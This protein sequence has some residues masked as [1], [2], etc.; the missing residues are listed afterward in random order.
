MRKGLNKLMASV[1]AGAMAMSVASTSF[2]A[3]A[4]DVEGT[5]YVEPTRVLSAL[6]IMVGDK[7]TGLFRPEDQIKRSEVAKIA[8][9]AMGLES[10]ALMSNGPTKYPD[11]VENHWANGYINV[12]TSQGLIIGDPDGNFRPDDSISY[13][14]AM[15]IMVRMIGHEPSALEKGGYPNG[16]LVVGA[17][18]DINKN[19]LGSA[20]DK[21]NRGTVAF[22]TYNS[23][24]VK[25][26]ERVGAGINAGYEEVDKTLLQ[27]KLKT[28][29][30][31]GQ[32]TGIE[33]TRLSGNSSLKDGEI[34][35]DGEVYKM[36]ENF[37]NLL[38]YN[39]RYYIQENDLG[40]KEVILAYAE[41]GK[42][43][44]EDI[45]AEQFYAIEDKGDSKIIKYKKNVNDNKVSSVE[46]EKEPTLIYNGKAENLDYDLI[47]LENK[48]GKINLL[49]TD[50]NG[51][52]DIIFVTEYKNIVVSD[53]LTSS[54]KIVDMYGNNALTLDPEDENIKF[55]IKKGSQNIELKD[56][57]KWDVLSIAA[58]KD[59][60]VYEI[61]V[62]NNKVEGKVDGISADEVSIGGVD[63]KIADNYKEAINLNTEGVFYLDI[64]GK[65]AAVD[66]TSAISNN[67]AY[68][69]NAACT[70]SMLDKCEIKVFTKEG[71]TEYKE[72]ASSIKLN[73]EARKTKED[74]LNAL[75]TGQDGAV[76]PQLITYELN[77]EGKVSRI[78][79][80]ND[81]SQTGAI[82]EETFTLNQKLEQATFNG[83]TG[84]LGN[85]NVNANTVIFNIPADKED[86]EDFAIADMSIFEHDAKYDAL[87]FDMGK[88]FTAKAIIVTSASLKTDADAK[89]AIVK[90]V[91][92]SLNAD[93]DIV[94]KLTAYC[95]GQEI[96]LLTE[97]EG[98]LVKGEDK[99]LEAGDI[100]QYKTNSKNEISDM[101]ILFD[102]N[103][104]DAEATNAPAE[105]LVT[106]YGKVVDKFDGSINVSVDGVVTNLNVKNAKVY[107]VDTTLSN[108][109][110][111]NAE[112]ADIEKYEGSDSSKVFV[113]IYKD[114]VQEIVIVK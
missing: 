54:H 82:D 112:T 7:D 86:E 98:F 17:E 46:L 42:N 64:E 41:A 24:E 109:V 39:V 4:S 33:N 102:I 58:S 74:V 89:I 16:Y 76:E 87:V 105:N 35:I 53:V 34:E 80:A 92:Q 37:N 104:K 85:V 62:I 67:Y 25:L 94:D 8:V 52:Y 11:V 107:N 27:N 32:V 95:D 14:E 114:V 21:V 6:N 70:D 28:E 49:D 48:A 113:K 3:V 75:Q 68:I 65:I 61:N 66:S 51:K 5:K 9:N 47:N 44:T 45:N 84:K 100:I 97:N 79:L 20:N 78:D 18:K 40:D 55:T 93:N 31:K 26:M 99:T 15:T 13:A 103:N 12:A 43:T 90:N 29:S 36:R 69:L 111:E 110:I 57:N 56:L 1:I 88:D 106:M 63:Y 23:L 72:L 83:V 77:S 22:M 19:A 59:K 10:I 38:G 96:S 91:K 30:G 108:T 81:N 73:G 2:A 50:R 60:T 101:R 71:K